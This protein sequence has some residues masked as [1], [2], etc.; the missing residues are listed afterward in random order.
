MKKLLKLFLLPV[1]LFILV[2][3]QISAEGD[4]PLE[5]EVEQG[6]LIMY[7]IDEEGNYVFEPMVVE[8]TPID[9]SFE[10]VETEGVLGTLSQKLRI[11]NATSGEVE[12]SVAL[13]VSTFED[14]AKWISG[15]D[16]FLA[17]STDG[18]DGGL[19]VD[20]SE[21][22]LEDEDCGGVTNNVVMPHRFTYIDD[23]NPETNITSIDVLNT[24]G[25]N[26]CRFDLTNLLLTQTIPP[27]T[28]AGNYTLGMVLTLTGGEWAA[29]PEGEF[30][31]GEVFID[32]RNDK[33]YSTAEIGVQCW[34]AE[35]LDYDD[36]C[37]S[38]TWENDEDKGW[39]GYYIDGGEPQEEYGLLYQWSAAM[40]WDGEGEPPIEGSQ[41]ICP[42]GWVL[43]NDSDLHT[44][45]NYLATE[46]CSGSRPASWD[47][48]PAGD[49]LKSSVADWCASTPCGESGFEALPAGMRNGS[50]PFYGFGIHA[51]FYSSSP[52]E[53]SG[54][55]SRSLSHSLST[56]HR[57]NSGDNGTNPQAYG[58][59]VRCLKD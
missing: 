26:E 37:S 8:F 21:I 40:D 11:D 6:D 32:S 52:T 53:F 55:W 10:F 54:V 23:E 39:C 14:D 48:E 4:I 18:L 44:L 58:Y 45:E 29:P 3:V 5:L 17:Y 22:D 36:G 34:M 27:R 1:F 43:P 38:V 41:G 47:C 50:G 33:E 12:L 51:F 19:L 59:S 7:Y 30:S 13:Y 16:E 24:S 15:E 9:T 49:Q 46:T 28:H 20:P 57:S 35:N 2:L 25:A 56:V 42:D 31:C